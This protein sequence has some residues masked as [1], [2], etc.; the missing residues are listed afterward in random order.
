L[1]AEFGLEKTAETLEVPQLG[2]YASVGR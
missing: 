1:P 2:G